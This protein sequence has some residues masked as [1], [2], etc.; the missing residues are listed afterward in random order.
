ML[1]S[2]ATTHPLPSTNQPTV[3]HCRTRPPPT[4]IILGYEDPIEMVDNRWTLPPWENCSHLVAVAVDATRT[5]ISSEPCSPPPL[6]PLR[7]FRIP[8]HGNQGSSRCCLDR[9]HTANHLEGI[10]VTRL[11]WRE[12]VILPSGHVGAMGDSHLQEDAMNIIQLCLEQ[13]FDW[14]IDGTKQYRLVMMVHH[15]VE[16][17]HL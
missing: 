15:A 13:V 3:D 7:K 4:R 1:H 10:V 6:H 11:R 8:I 12:A 16:I 14:R 2:T 17:S 5:P 9:R